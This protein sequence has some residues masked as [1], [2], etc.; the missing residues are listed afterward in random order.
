[1]KIF[2]LAGRKES[3]EKKSLTLLAMCLVTLPM[4]ANQNGV[5]KK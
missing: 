4:P 1:M 3:Q 5:W 2:N